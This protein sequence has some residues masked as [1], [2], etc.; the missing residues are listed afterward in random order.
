MHVDGDW[1]A[2]EVVLSKDIATVGE[3]LQIWNLK[4]SAAKMVSAAFH[5]NNKEAKHALKVN[6]SNPAL[7]PRAK[8]LGATLDR[9]L[10]YHWNLE[11]LCIL[12]EA[13]ITP[14]H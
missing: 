14:R 2:V 1:Q 9:S 7:L 5:L 11:S 8:Y 13:D 6:Y 10:M 12:Q 3:Y 4:L